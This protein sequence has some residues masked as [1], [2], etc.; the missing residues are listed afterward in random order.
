M[1]AEVTDID[2]DERA[3]V[4]FDVID[5]RECGTEKFERRSEAIVLEDS[6]MSPESLSSV[7]RFLLEDEV[8]SVIVP[9][10]LTYPL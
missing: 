10:L 2:I 5:E 1:G 7:F 8:L 9:A 4:G 3:V 6:R